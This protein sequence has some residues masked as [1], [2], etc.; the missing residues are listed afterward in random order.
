LHRLEK[1]G[2]IDVDASWPSAST[3]KVRVK[4][5][6]EPKEVDEEDMT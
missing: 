4:K 3:I 5:L 1:L 6:L 2:L